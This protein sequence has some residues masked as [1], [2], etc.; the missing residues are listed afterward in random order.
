MFFVTHW[1]TVDP[2]NRHCAFN[3]QFLMSDTAT[4]TSLTAQVSTPILGYRCVVAN[5]WYE[6]SDRAKEK[7]SC[8]GQQL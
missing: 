5:L 8:V 4:A 7:K 2:M 3:L 1:Q 6:N